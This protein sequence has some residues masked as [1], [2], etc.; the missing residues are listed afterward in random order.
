MAS[1]WFIAGVLVAIGLVSAAAVYV[2]DLW[3]PYGVLIPGLF[4]GPEVFLSALRSFRAGG[5]F[6]CAVAIWLVTA[7]V[8][9]YH[10]F[11]HFGMS[12]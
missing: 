9:Y 3:W 12:Q 10:V 11:A 1:I 6:L 2:W 8:I 4:F 5:A 7:A